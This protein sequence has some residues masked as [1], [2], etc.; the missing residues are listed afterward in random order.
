MLGHKVPHIKIITKL[1]EYGIRGLILDW[2]EGFLRKK[3][4]EGCYVRIKLKRNRV[5]G[6]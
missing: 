6:I 5:G 3:E 1:D 4:A 2:I